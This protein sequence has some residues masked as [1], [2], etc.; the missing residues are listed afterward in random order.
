M[1]A[2]NWP[3]VCHLQ[4]EGMSRRPSSNRLERPISS[5]RI[6]S[7]GAHIINTCKTRVVK[8]DNY[9]QV[10]EEQDRSFEIIALPFAVHVAEQ[11]DTEYHSNHIPLWE[12]EAEGV[13]NRD[14]FGCPM[15][16]DSAEQNQRW[17]L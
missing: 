10:T 15:G 17:N 8:P 2:R 16:V 4:L 6:K 14:R 9:H 5:Q 12:N 11:E 13:L 1:Q 3:P 7:T